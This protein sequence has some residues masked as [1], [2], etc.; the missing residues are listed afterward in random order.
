LSKQQTT[1]HTVQLP[2]SREKK[3]MS[4]PVDHSKTA[5]APASCPAH[6]QGS[7][8]DTSTKAKEI[9]RSKLVPIPQPSQHLFGLLGNLPDIEDKSFFFASV[10][11]LQGIY[12]P[13]LQL[14][15]PEKRLCSY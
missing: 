8:A 3:D 6:T 12:G 9:D 13:L 4:C 15:M 10:W 2:I 14:N 7:E 11:K 1:Q 5:E